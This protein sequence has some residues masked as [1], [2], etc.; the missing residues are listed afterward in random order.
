MTTFQTKTI[1]LGGRA[2][3]PRTSG[4]SVE[5]PGPRL[6]PFG[7]G[8]GG[9]DGSGW[10]RCAPSQGGGGTKLGLFGLG[11]WGHQAGAV[12][13]GAVES[14]ELVRQ[15]HVVEAAASGGTL[16]PWC[17]VRA[18]VRRERIEKD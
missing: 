18:G 11:R 9:G 1:L 4:G 10:W 16:H 12:Q 6:G 8:G 17:A 15:T 14:C 13:A 7:H 2:G 3:S 5:A